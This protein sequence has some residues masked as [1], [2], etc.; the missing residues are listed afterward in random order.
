MPRKKH[1]FKFHFF[2]IYTVS[3][4]GKIGLIVA[5]CTFL[6]KQNPNHVFKQGYCS[7]IFSREEAERERSQGFER[8][9][10]S[11]CRP[12]PAKAS[13]LRWRSSPGWRPSSRSC[14]PYGSHSWPSPPSTTDQ[15][16]FVAII[17][18]RGKQ[19]NLS[20]SLM[21]FLV[22]K[23]HTQG[24]SRN[25]P[26]FKLQL[27]VLFFIRMSLIPNR[28]WKNKKFMICTHWAIHV[29]YHLI[30]E[31]GPRLLSLLELLVHFFLFFKL[32]IVIHTVNNSVKVRYLLKN[33][34]ENITDG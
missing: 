21:R 22:F 2:I 17:T 31:L 28:P 9:T 26:Y 16:R 8:N 11:Q 3:L 4:S 29:I 7:V 18:N 10:W 1:R 19:T 12:G 6:C 34:L 20:L 13:C 5:V 32:K 14:T 25:K 15:C 27:T 24:S 30:E 23:T 33:L